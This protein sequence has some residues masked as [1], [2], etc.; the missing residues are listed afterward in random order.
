MEDVSITTTAPNSVARRHR[1]LVSGSGPETVVLGN[2]FGT[3][4]F[5]W[6]ALVPWF[7]RRY[8]V[9]RFDWV[10]DSARPDSAIDGFADD[11]LAV[12][13]VTSSLP[14]TFV[15]H[16]MSGMIGMLAAQRAPSVFRR[17]VMIAPGSPLYQRR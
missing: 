15:A 7:E 10:M 1:I 5:F 12:L 9:V 17:M 11:L 4:Q 3:D 8:R 16:S 13:Q 2:G 6:R 14:C